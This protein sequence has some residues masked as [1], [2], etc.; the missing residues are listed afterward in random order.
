MYKVMIIDDEE[1]VRIGIRNLLDWEGEEYT[2]CAEGSDG[3]DGLQKLLEH[4]PNLVLVD[5]KMPGLSGIE[6]IKA[7]REQNY[8]GYF[9]ILTGFSEFEFA[10]SAISLGVKEYLLKPID[11]EELLKII[12]NIREEIEQTEGV[13]IYHTNNEEIAR[14]KLLRKI[15]LR[16]EQKEELQKQLKVYKMDFSKQNLC[17]AIIWDKEIAS[18]HENSQFMNKVKVLLGN[19]D[20][21]TEK[22]IMD[23]CMV[24]IN[25][26]MDYKTW[27]KALSKQ[28]ERVLGKYERGL[29]ISVGHNVNNWYDL[30]YSYEFA[31]FLMEHEFLFSSSNILTLDH[32]EEPKHMTDNPSLEH[33]LMLIEVGD[34]EGIRECVNEFRQ[35]CIKGM[36]NELDIKVQVMYNLMQVK[37]WAEKKNHSG[38]VLEVAALME[39]LNQVEELNGLLEL[40]SRILQDLC[41]QIG[42][43]GSETVIKR[44][45]YYMEKNYGKELKLETF[46]KMFGYNSNY[47][48]KMFRKEMGDSFNNILDTIRI[49]NAKRL[50]EETNFKVYEISER[51]GYSN[52]DY[53]YLKFKKYVGISPTEYKKGFS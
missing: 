41:M 27:A 28:N 19:K 8:T 35:Y 34:I 18:S 52:I 24:I 43:D 38:K 12:R 44:M 47:L 30:S 40:Y 3:R 22:V 31:K 32:I 23:D 45:Y 9:I 51:V 5:I 53:F 10:K 2:I 13:Q 36:K 16:L 25:R 14:E 33:V 6:L 1:T 7:A 11:E 21:Y 50:L 46:S 26:D 37:S 29:L 20:L 42:C 17:A 49:T 4:N 15:L 39:E 48:G